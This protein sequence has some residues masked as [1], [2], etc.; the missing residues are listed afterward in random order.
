MYVI[1]EILVI[2]FSKYQFCLNSI[3]NYYYVICEMQLLPA[4]FKRISR[5]T[6]FINWT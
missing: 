2:N 5:P 6:S 1:T 4:S 3:E